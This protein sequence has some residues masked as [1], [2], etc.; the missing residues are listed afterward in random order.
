MVDTSAY[1]ALLDDAD[2]HHREAA[3]II[4]RL[5][6]Q[7]LRPYTTNAVLFESHALIMSV[8]GIRAAWEF[9][10]ETEASSTVVIR[11]RASDEARAKQII[12]RYD[13]KDFSYT[14]AL[15]F[16]VM[17]RLRIPQAFAFD[18]HFGQYGWQVLQAE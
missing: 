11:V 2:Q 3:A 7:H 17:E 6:E 9:L 15:S 16:A 10:Q 18:R 5:A 4:N 1:L 12:A 8:L 13:D 14:D